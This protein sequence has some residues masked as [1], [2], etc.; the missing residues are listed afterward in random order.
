M[1]KFCLAVPVLNQKESTLETLR[2]YY[3]MATYPE[4]IPLILIDNGSTPP[5]ASWLFDFSKEFPLVK[6][7]IIH[8]QENVG[9]TKSLNQAWELTKEGCC[10]PDFIFYSHSDVLIQE[11]GWDVKVKT[12]LEEIKPI[13]VMGFGGAKGIGTP[14]LY[15]EPYVISQL[16][17]TGFFSNMQDAENHGRR[18]TNDVEPCAVLDGFTLIVNTKL[19]EEID[20]FDE[21]YKFH[22]YDEDLCVQAIQHG[23]FNF[24]LNIACKHNGG[25]TST[26]ADY[27]TWLRKQNINGDLEI[28]Q[29]AHTYFYEKFRGFIPLMFYGGRYVRI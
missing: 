7:R 3:S 27:D 13:G 25:R 11:L 18:M 12:A 26:S 14:D 21:H 28:H 5:V 20:G 10:K 22:M 9:V 19:L 23:Y 4:D 15:K 17:R 1:I 6:V 29:E 16:I 8:N 24:V 2:S